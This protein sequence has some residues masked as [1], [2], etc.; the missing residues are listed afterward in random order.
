MKQYVFIRKIFLYI[1]RTPDYYF[2][3]LGICWEMEQLMLLR[4]LAFG[5][6]GILILVPMSA[7]GNLYDSS[8]TLF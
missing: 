6:L 8:C 1:Q 3:L 2:Q 5:L 4:S 7:H